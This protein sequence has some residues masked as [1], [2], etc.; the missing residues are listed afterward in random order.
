[1]KHEV[2]MAAVVKVAEWPVFA[3]ITMKLNILRN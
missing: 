2:V 1:M 3:A